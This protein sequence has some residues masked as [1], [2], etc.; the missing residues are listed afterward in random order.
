M[1]IMC[2]LKKQMREKL[3]WIIDVHVGKT[4]TDKMLTISVAIPAGVSHYDGLL[5]LG[6][7][8]RLNQFYAIATAR[9]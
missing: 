8:G 2:V 6:E 7:V 5:L 9:E 3:G 4:R 1:L